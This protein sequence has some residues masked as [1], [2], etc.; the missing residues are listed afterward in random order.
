MGAL[1]A[2]E[3][4]PQGMIGVGLIYRWYRR[5]AL[6]PDDAVAVT[7]APAEL[8]A[9]PLSDALI[10]IRRSLSA[11]TRRGLLSRDD[12]DAEAER[13]AALPFPDRHLPPS[14]EAARVGQKASDA[15]A[16]LNRLARHCKE[17]DWPHIEAE[18]PPIVHAWLDDLEDSGLRFPG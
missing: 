12:A 17:N 5:F 10:D 9:H 13:I 16:L 7:H 1:R 4:A 18:T 8:G 15:C 14:L 6:L 11:A 2:A 3:L